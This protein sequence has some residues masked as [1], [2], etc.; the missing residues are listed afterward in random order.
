[1]AMRP[2]GEWLWEH[3]WSFC[4]VWDT[5]AFRVFALPGYRLGYDNIE[6]NKIKNNDE[7]LTVY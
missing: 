1:M 6:N 7:L 4:D 2:S 5:Q 3:R